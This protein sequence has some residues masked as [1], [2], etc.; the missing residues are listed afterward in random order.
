[1]GDV[2]RLLDRLEAI[3]PVLEDLRRGLLH[4]AEG[5]DAR[6]GAFETRVS[7]IAE[8]AKV[9][10]VKHMAMRTDEAARKSIDLQSRAMADAARVAFGVE[11]GATM[12][13]LQTALQPLLDRRQRRW[14]LWLSH[15]AIVAASSA[16]TFALTMY[17][18]PR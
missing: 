15:A 2:A 5:L 12:Q 4:A 13:R 1:I 7:A 14:G 8:N 16:T 11:L 18:V 10:T 17:F 6:I 9:Q 3:A